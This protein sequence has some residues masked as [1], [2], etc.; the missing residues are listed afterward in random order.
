M[1]IQIWTPNNSHKRIFYARQYVH[2]RQ[3]DTDHVQAA[4]L[5]NG[6]YAVTGY[7][8][9]AGAKS[10]VSY[11]TVRRVRKAEPTDVQIG[12][13]EAIA[14]CF[15]MTLLEF[16]ADFD[17]STELLPEERAIIADMRR[18]HNKP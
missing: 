4:E 7:K 14:E 2:G 12:H 10:G 3:N 6:Y 16:V 5:L 18:C 13:V 8:R 9:E 1:I 17:E 11:G 15:G